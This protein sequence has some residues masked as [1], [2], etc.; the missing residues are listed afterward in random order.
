MFAHS[1]KSAAAALVVLAAA[2]VPVSA[3]DKY[4]PKAY[5]PSSAAKPVVKSESKDVATSD[6][7]FYDTF[8]KYS[9]DKTYD[10]K[11]WKK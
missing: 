1:L 6:F 2:G 11:S 10:P 4:A 3:A 9:D 7:K 5:V 8:S